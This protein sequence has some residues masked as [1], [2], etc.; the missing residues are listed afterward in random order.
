MSTP[1]AAPGTAAPTTSLDVLASMGPQG[2][3]V[4]VITQATIDASDSVVRQILALNPGNAAYLRDVKRGWAIAVVIR[5]N[6]E[7]A[8][9]GFL[10]LRNRTHQLLGLPRT[11]ALIGHALTVRKYRGQGLQAISIHTRAQLAFD[12]G[13][14]S[15]CAETDLQNLASQHG[16]LKAGM[17]RLGSVEIIRVLRI[18]VLRP[19]RPAGF[20]FFSWCL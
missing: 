3:S 4:M 19:A 5:I 1:S 9:H 12:A 14:R 13:F 6:D 10:F 15:V 16:M 8:H 17:S 11:S 20:P 2:S 7:L 18:I